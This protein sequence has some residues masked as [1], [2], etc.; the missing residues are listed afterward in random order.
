MDSQAWDARYRTVDPVWGEA[1]NRWVVRE[2]EDLPPG[3]ALDL[4]AGEGRNSIWLVGRGWQAVAV[5][6]SEVALERGRAL[7]SALPEEYAD[8]IAWV[9]A[10]VLTHTPVRDGFDLVLVVY[11][12][13]PAADRRTALQLAAASLAPRGTLLVVG[14]DTS[15]LTEGVGGPQDARVL[16]TPEDV[17]ADLDGLGLE[18]VRA[19]RVRRA[20]PAP[21]GHGTA[22][23]AVDAL[24]RMHRPAHDLFP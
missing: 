16:F 8:R 13:L 15:N 2:C 7:A 11:L 14:H 9:H 24:V 19:E 3:E 20:V 22:G 5:D 10:D 12:Q 23:E 6:F 1:P 17:L 21:D 18:T 4:A